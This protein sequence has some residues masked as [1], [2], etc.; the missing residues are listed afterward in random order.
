MRRMKL[1]GGLLIAL[2]VFWVWMIVVEYAVAFMHPNAHFAFNWSDA[3][4]IVG[5]LVF[6]ILMLVLGVV[7]WRRKPKNWLW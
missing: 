2:G 1:I 7:M 4:E 6:G 3:W 5:Y